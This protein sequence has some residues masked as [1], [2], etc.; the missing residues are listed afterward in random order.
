MGWP[1]DVS[2]ARHI[3]QVLRCRG[4]LAHPRRLGQTLRSLDPREA[5]ARKPPL[6]SRFNQWKPAPLGTALGR[7]RPRTGSTPAR[8]PRASRPYSIPLS[9][10][11][12]RA[13]ASA[14]S[15]IWLLSRL[16]NPTRP[17]CSPVASRWRWAPTCK[18]THRGRDR[19]AWGGKLRVVVDLAYEVLLR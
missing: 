11:L 2:T 8:T 3:S 1:K 16:E 17:R 6:A 9:L 12:G 18:G 10:K 14:L 15:R 5:M 19:F 4:A 7:Y 13:K